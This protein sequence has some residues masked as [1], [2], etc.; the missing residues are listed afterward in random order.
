[1]AKVYVWNWKL[2]TGK[3]WDF[4]SVSINKEKIIAAPEGKGYIKLLL[5]ELREPD[6][7]GNT[8]SLFY[9]DDYQP[10]SNTSSTDE[11]VDELF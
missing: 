9:D 8:H 2:L 10:K 7:F 5:T 6:K 1:M 11:V 4:F 3:Y